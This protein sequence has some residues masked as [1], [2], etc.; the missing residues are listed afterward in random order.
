MMIVAADGRCDNVA[1]WRD[2][3]T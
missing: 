2:Q 1:I 3:D